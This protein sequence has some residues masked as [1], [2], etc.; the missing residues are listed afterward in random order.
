MAGNF[1]TTTVQGTT[2]EVWDDFIARA[3]FARNIT[4]GK[5]KAIRENGYI[6]NDLTIRKA[7]ADH[8]GLG[9]FRK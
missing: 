7:I 3:T 6:G 5:T 2:Y 4:T 1:K 8:F 9:S